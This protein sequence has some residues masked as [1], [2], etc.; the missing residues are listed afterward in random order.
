LVVCPEIKCDLL[1]G[2]VWGSITVACDNMLNH[3]R[4]ISSCNLRKQQ[5][6]EERIK[7]RPARSL[8]LHMIPDRQGTADNVSISFELM[9]YRFRR[10][11]RI[12]FVSILNKGETTEMLQGK[13]LSPVWSFKSPNSCRKF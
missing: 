7:E 11:F 4:V 10:I 8:S 1:R 5:N 13:K 9:T 2:S 3:Q 6:K 12:A